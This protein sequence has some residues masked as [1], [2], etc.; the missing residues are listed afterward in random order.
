MNDTNTNEEDDIM[1]LE[2][3]HCKECGELVLKKAGDKKQITR[4]IQH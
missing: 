1:L 3:D 2:S 4:C